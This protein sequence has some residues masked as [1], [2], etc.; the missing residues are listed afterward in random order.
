MLEYITVMWL[1]AGRLAYISAMALSVDLQKF[2][3]GV[4]E[5][6]VAFM[7][8]RGLINPVFALVRGF[9]KDVERVT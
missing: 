4:D 1:S 3:R 9:T 8:G 2:S 6:G 5:D 7:L